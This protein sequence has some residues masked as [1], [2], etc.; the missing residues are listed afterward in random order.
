MAQDENDSQ[1]EGEDCPHPNYLH[2]ASM[3]VMGQ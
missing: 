2:A 3:Y 1:L